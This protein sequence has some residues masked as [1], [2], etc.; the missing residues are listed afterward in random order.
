MP[1]KVNFNC[2]KIFYLLIVQLVFKDK[3]RESERGRAEGRGGSKGRGRK[4]SERLLSAPA[5]MMLL[6]IFFLP[7][8]TAR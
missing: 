6:I 8:V 1:K 3:N 5:D 4:K 2:F 7:S